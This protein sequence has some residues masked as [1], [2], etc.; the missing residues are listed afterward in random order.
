MFLSVDYALACDVL[1][2]F[3]SAAQALGVWGVSAFLGSTI[4]PLVAGPLLA[5]FGWTPSPERY[6]KDGYLAVNTVGALCVM[7]SAAFLR[8]VTAR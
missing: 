3:E 8:R 2:S 6:A 4:G 5:Y 7:L 1:P